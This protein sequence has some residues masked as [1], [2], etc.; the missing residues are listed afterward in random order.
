MIRLKPALLTLIYLFALFPLGAHAETLTDQTIR[1]F[2]SSLEELQ[3]M[4][5]EF[6]ELTEDLAA[7]EDTM[8]MPDMSR[9]LSSSVEQ[10]KGHAMYSEIEDVVRQHGFSSA[11]QWASTGDR[12]FHAWSALE[13]GE[14]SAQMNQEMARAMEEIDNNPNMSEAQKQQMREMMGGA[15]SAFEG[16]ANAPEADKQA[17]RPHMDALRS[18]MNSDPEF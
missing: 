16:A 1:A 9:I 15:M 8:E 10:M 3:S 6:T 2:I 7:D 12:I 17:V 18:A 13:M 11:E 4:E 5:D 14:Q